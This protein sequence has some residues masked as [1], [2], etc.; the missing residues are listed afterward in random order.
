VDPVS[1][2]IP[3]YNPPA[4]LLEAVASAHSQT[5]GNI[6]VI[7]V[8]DGTDR[9]EGLAVVRQCSGQADVYIEQENR[10]LT[11][12]RNAGFRAARGR[13]IVPLDADDLL[14]REYVTRCIA[15]LDSDPAAAFAYTD[16]QVFGSQNYAENPGEYNLYRLL[17]QNFLTY[18]ALI[19]KTD[20]EQAGGYDE[21]MRLGY[22]DWEFWL[23]LGG[24]GRFGR[25]VP[26]ALFR[27]RKHGP[28]LY[29]IA[30]AR[31]TE[32]VAY[33]QGR[34]PELYEYDAQARIKARWSPAVCIVSSQPPKAQ[35]IED[36]Q[37]LDA[38][39]AG[40]L[41]ARSPAAAFLLCSSGEI[42][43]NSAEMAA[44]AVWSGN[45]WQTLPDGS[46]AISR[47]VA[48]SVT[49]LSGFR[50]AAT[51]AAR[52][53]T[54]RK[55][56]LPRKVHRH[57]INADLLSWRSWVQHPLRSA[58]RLIPLR[59]KERINR[60]AGRPFFDLSFYLQ[61]QPSSVVLGNRLIE[62]LRYFPH[63]SGDRS[64]LA[65][66]VPHLGPGGAESVLLD[67][68]AAL[69]RKRFEVLLLATQSR[70]D[71]WLAKWNVQ[72][73]HIYDLARV[74]PPARMTAAICSVVANWGCDAVLV[75]NSLYGYAA[76]PAIKRL[77]PETK[78]L[79]IIHALDEAWDQVSTIFEVA[80]DLD[81]RVAVSDAVRDRLLKAGIPAQ[82]VR[83]VRGGV[84]LDRFRPAPAH[85]DREMKQILFAGRLD[86]VK[87]PLLL[88][89][90]ATRLLALRTRRDFR[91][92]IAGDGPEMR[93]FRKRVSREGLQSLFEFHGHVDHLPPL[94]SAS[95]VVILPSRAEGIPLVVLEA[96]A[97]SR[98]V[99]ASNVGAI[100]EVLTPDCGVLI[101]VGRSEAAAFA[102]ALDTLLNQ[103]E[104]REKMGAA[105]RKKIEA[106]YDVRLTRKIYSRLLL[107]LA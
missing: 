102:G 38:A 77:A 11:A 20:W 88:V 6:E 85:F 93:S 14:E 80:K 74:V 55:I 43:A 23:R 5:Y 12:A 52:L 95:D 44:L 103:P 28:S 2:V 30:K 63:A 15:A 83:V 41:T 40:P 47:R 107:N 32:L 106:E 76:L 17:D 16:F 7:L 73:D 66:V 81:L 97:C 31:H 4:Y 61:F 39:G 89:D 19:R 82:K 9:A 94:F 59:V 35:S 56:P 91:F 27:Y 96:L 36:V 86:P 78:S 10:G 18:A 33:I 68:V 62:P 37:K 72:V 57:L 8:N 22:E 1:I 87:R 92:L 69:C 51:A 3:C 60:A 58:L 75:Q 42:A 13:Y 54:A 25:H 50:P 70:D 21:S 26:M 65:L 53:G 79:D 100:G 45:D 49:D 34:H 64:R 99:V 29:D 84:D 24:R 98:P 90:I 104:L 105:G 101:D 71:R 48:A 67:I 46:H